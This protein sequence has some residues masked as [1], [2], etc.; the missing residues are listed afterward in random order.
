MPTDTL[1]SLAILKVN[2][3]HGRDYLDYIRP[4]ILNVLTVEHPEIITDGVVGRLILKHFGLEIPDQVVEIVLRRVARRRYIERDHG[5]YRIAR[6]LPKSRMNSKVSDAE[7]HIKAVVDGLKQFSIE[8]AKPI[9]SDN[10][11]IA[12]ICAFLSEFDITCLRSALRETAIPVLGGQHRTEIVLVSEY[13]RHLRQSAPVRFKSFIIL[14][15]GHMLANALTCPDLRHAPKN[16]RNVKFYIDTPLLVRA[17]G[18]DGEEMRDAVL[19]TL[20]LVSSLGG[21][22]SAFSHSREE[23]R[24]VLQSAA[25]SLDVPNAQGAIVFE[26]RRKGSTRSDLL[27]LA[28]S[29]DDY[30]SAANIEVEATPSYIEE[31]QIDESVFE[32]ALDDEVSYF[33]P[34]AKE[35]DINSV[36]SIYVIRATASAPSLEKSR[37]VFVTSNSGFAKAAWEYGQQYES[38]KNVSSVITDFSLANIAWLKE[39]M[40][41]PSIPTSQLLAFSYAALQPP[42]ELL[43][44]YLTEI[45]RLETQGTITERDH[46]LLRSSP[47]VHGELMTMTLGEEEALTENTITET[48]ARVSSEIRKEETQKL[49]K[50]QQEHRETREAL[51]REE[52]R[53]NQVTSRVYLRCRRKAKFLAWSASTIVTVSIVSGL[54]SGIRFYGDVGI[55]ASMVG[56]GSVVLGAMTL[57]NLVFGIS[58]KGGHD[59]LERRLLRWLLVRESNATGIDFGDR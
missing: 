25:D 58:V 47:L 35:Y 12:A 15:Q 1:T 7:A 49:T 57:A 16:F 39:P 4:F 3:D 23:L 34:R 33:N 11:A 30:L 28:E 17:I 5:V 55:V 13:V 41:Q 10:E 48:L 46:Q 53:R 24:R 52:E 54:A 43:D 50:E 14:V 18:A 20:N 19:A 51:S 38:S 2:L 9:T 32:K 45:D 44:K 26:A 21:R 40:Q 42:S 31:F 22:I 8:T 36:R 56:G 6:D 27:L 59:W 29:I 37:A